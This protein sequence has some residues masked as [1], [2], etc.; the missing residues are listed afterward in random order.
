KRQQVN[1]LAHSK[2]GCDRETRTFTPYVSCPQCANLII[3]IIRIIIWTK[4][5]SFSSEVRKP[6]FPRWRRLHSPEALQSRVGNRQRPVAFVARS[7]CLSGIRSSEVRS[8]NRRLWVFGFW[9]AA[10]LSLAG[11]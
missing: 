1:K 4:G 7:Q 2:R 5:P 6:P 9:R 3:L 8:L 11:L 10:V